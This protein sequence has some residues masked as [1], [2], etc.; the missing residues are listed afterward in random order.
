M[1][2][3][4][5]CK[6]INEKPCCTVAYKQTLIHIYIALSLTPTTHTHAHHLPSLMEWRIKS[7]TLAALYP[8]THSPHS[9]SYASRR[10]FTSPQEWC[11]SLPI[12]PNPSVSV[13]PPR[14]S[15]CTSAVFFFSLFSHTGRLTGCSYSEG[16]ASALHYVW[17]HG[18]ILA[19]C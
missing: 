15:S 11:N 14:G 10:C 3:D 18:E 19:C 2:K 1:D 7:L 8:S 9:L 13:L 5:T 16:A 6:F 17:C 12:L 4:T